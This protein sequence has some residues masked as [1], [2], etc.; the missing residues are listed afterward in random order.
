MG[1]ALTVTPTSGMAIE[2]AIVVGVGKP[3]RRGERAVFAA[4]GWG[5]LA[6]KLVGLRAGEASVAPAAK[7]KKG[8]R[9]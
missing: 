3:H 1:S 6:G 5:Y 2:R 4:Y 7:V 8:K 9:G